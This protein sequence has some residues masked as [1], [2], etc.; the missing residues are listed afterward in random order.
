[1]KLLS[2]NPWLGDKF[3]A[4]RRHDAENA[5]G[6]VC[7]L[8]LRRSHR[9]APTFS[10]GQMLAFAALIAFAVV[11]VNAYLTMQS[12]S[13]PQHDGDTARIIKSESPPAFSSDTALPPTPSN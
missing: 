11:I 8:D 2:E 1:M 13:A 7:I 10:L 6:F 9:D 4:L 3:H 5:E 12:E